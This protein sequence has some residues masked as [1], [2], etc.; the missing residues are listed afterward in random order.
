MG[1]ITLRRKHWKKNVLALL[2]LLWAGNVL[3]FVAVGLGEYVGRGHEAELPGLAVA[4][5]HPF[6]YPIFRR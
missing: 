2:C 4:G 5:E 6:S 1:K 3:F